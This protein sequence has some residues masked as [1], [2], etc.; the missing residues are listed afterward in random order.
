MNLNLEN[1]EIMSFDQLM[2]SAQTAHLEGQHDEA[3]CFRLAAYDSA[4]E[5]PFNKGRAGRDVAASLDRIGL[6]EPAV[7]WADEAYGVHDELVQSTTTDLVSAQEARK[8]KAKTE[9]EKSSVSD[10]TTDTIVKDPRDERSKNE[11]STIALKNKVQEAIRE[12]AA[13]GMYVGSLA[14]RQAINMEQAK[15]PHEEHS[16][17]ALKYLRGAITDINEYERYHRGT[18]DQYRINM[19]GRVALAEGLYGEKSMGIK[20]GLSQLALAPVSENAGIAPF[21]LHMPFPDRWKA[22]AKAAARGAGAIGATLLSY[23]PARGLALRVADR[24]L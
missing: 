24:V 14:L 2:Q 9:Q 21:I 7:Q 4:V 23:R 1:I 16:N 10:T 8:K 22:R 19:T 3:L 13:S 6:T 20:L 11:D 15:E 18:I 5:S 17:K 12:R